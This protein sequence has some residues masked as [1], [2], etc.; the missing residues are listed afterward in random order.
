LRQLDAVV[1]ERREEILA[2][3]RDGLRERLLRRR[4]RVVL[5]DHVR[6]DAAAAVHDATAVRLEGRPALLR[7]VGLVRV[8]LFLDE[9][10]IHELAR[11]LDRAAARREPLARRD[12]EG[13][14][15]V[16]LVHALDEALAEA[17]L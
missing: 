17:G 13:V 15:A 8:G 14:A 9:L 11:A 12:L 4:Q 5:D 2:L 3:R 7:R 16:E 10:A 1:G 6:G